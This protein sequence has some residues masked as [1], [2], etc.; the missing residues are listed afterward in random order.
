MWA[1]GFFLEQWNVLTLGYVCRTKTT[2]EVAESYTASMWALKEKV[3]TQTRLYLDLQVFYNK[4]VNLL[5]ATEK[6]GARLSIDVDKEHI[7]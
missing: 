7:L 4:C 2:Q 5:P 6:Q 1:Q 3:K